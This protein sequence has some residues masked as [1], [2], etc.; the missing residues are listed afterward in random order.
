MR[1]LQN[2]TRSELDFYAAQPTA[3]LLHERIMKDSVYVPP[4][5]KSAAAVYVAGRGTEKAGVSLDKAE[6]SVEGR[7]LSQVEIAA[8]K[9]AKNTPN[10]E[11][12][13]ARWGKG[14]RL[15]VSFGNSAM[16]NRAVEQGYIEIDGRRVDFSDDVKNRLTAANKQIQNA[17]QAVSLKNMLLHEAASA[18]QANDAMKAANDKMSRAMKTAARIMHGKKVSPADEKELMEF[19]KDLYTMAKSAAALEDYRRKKHDKEDEKISAE[20]DAARAKEAEPKDYSVEEVPL[21]QTEVQMD[22]DLDAD[23]PEVLSVGAGVTE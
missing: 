13:V 22:I 21:P 3:K 1:I 16:V 18:R 5:D 14:N 4:G 8:K 15:T 19:N 10:I 12:S 2:L 9:D 23:I 17:K 7:E 11:F 20:N 6:I